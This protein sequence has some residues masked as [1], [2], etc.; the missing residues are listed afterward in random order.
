MADETI[1]VTSEAVRFGSGELEY[2]VASFDESR[3]IGSAR[4]HGGC[5][6]WV[7]IRGLAREI[8]RRRV[9]T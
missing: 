8:E 2:H 7:L 4:R 9:R 3:V 1:G 6:R 5:G